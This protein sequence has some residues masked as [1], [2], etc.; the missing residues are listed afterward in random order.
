MTL[1]N[2]SIWRKLFGTW[3][4]N[5]GSKVYHLE[6]SDW[7]QS[8]RAECG[9]DIRNPGFTIS[10]PHTSSLAPLRPCKRCLKRQALGY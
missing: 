5:A 10:A 9:A 7:V 1:E 8:G 4:R 2:N 3:Y 6:A